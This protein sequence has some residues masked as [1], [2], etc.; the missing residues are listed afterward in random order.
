MPP[1]TPCR[2]TCRNRTAILPR[3]TCSSTGDYWGPGT[4]DWGLGPILASPQSQVPNPSRSPDIPDRN[5]PL[6]AGLRAW[7][8]AER[9]GQRI[10]RLVGAD[11]AEVVGAEQV[12]HL[13]NQLDLARAAQAQSLG[14]A[15]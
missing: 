7:N 13:S 1:V 11:A 5:L 8:L 14:D 10:G 4:R 3:T 6:L 15:H 2:R 12:E 9:R